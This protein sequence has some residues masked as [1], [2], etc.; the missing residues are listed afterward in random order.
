MAWIGDKLRVKAKNLDPAMLS[1]TL[2]KFYIVFADSNTVPVH[3]TALY[4]ETNDAVDN[5]QRDRGERDLVVQ[6]ISLLKRAL[7]DVLAEEI[8]SHGKGIDGLAYKCSR[9]KNGFRVKGKREFTGGGG[10]EHV[11]DKRRPT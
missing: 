1:S 9:P 6:H 4:G 8:T 7:P 5:P 11:P 3:W 2:S 10:A